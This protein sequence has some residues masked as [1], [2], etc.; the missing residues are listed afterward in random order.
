MCVLVLV[1]VICDTRFVACEASFIRLV[2]TSH[3]L[4]P[5]SPRTWVDD[6]K[7]DRIQPP[8]YRLSPIAYLLNSA[9]TA[10]AAGKGSSARWKMPSE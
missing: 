6:P 7:E 3:H 5:P 8:G 9:Y 2:H 10:S 1:A 4:R